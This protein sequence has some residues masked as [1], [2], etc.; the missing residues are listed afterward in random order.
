MTAVMLINIDVDDVERAVAFYTAAFGLKVGRRL[1]PFV[2]EL[3]GGSSPMYLLAKSAGSP[4]SAPTGEQRR[5]SRHW[6]P[7]HLDFVVSDLETALE[8]ALS[9]GATLEAQPARHVW[10][11]IARLADP[12]GHGVCLIEFIGRG[13]DEIA[14]S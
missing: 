13:Y 8:A 5:Y 1:G 2:V 11:K 14:T 6:T 10:G 12:F 4:A 7:I 3:T 9:A